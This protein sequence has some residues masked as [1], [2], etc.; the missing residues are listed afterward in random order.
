M[1]NKMIPQMTRRMTQNRWAGQRGGGGGVVQED[2]GRLPLGHFPVPRRRHQ[3]R[4]LGPGHSF[5]WGGR[6]A[7]THR[8]KPLQG[9]GGRPSP[10]S[11][12][13]K[14][15]NIKKRLCLGHLLPQLVVNAEAVPVH[16][17]AGRGRPT[18]RPTRV[19]GHPFLEEGMN[20]WLNI[21]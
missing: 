11:P 2:P 12:T 20:G 1:G 4:L 7:A 16:H 5:G 3:L 21:E 9:G 17:R 10:A 15:K 13:V 18:P 19:A 6:W 8:P 14:K